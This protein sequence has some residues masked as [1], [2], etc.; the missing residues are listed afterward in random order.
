MAL[1][2]GTTADL[3]IGVE[4][5]TLLLL[6]LAPTRHAI[7]RRQVAVMARIRTLTLMRAAIV[8]A[9]VL[10][11]STGVVATGTVTRAT[12]KAA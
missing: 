5:G 10:A 11:R 12:S 2:V 7:R 1:R 3:R 9:A 6:L 4:R 8:A